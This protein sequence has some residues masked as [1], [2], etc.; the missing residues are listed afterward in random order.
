MQ[1]SIDYEDIPSDRIIGSKY[2]IEINFADKMQAFN[3]TGT[4]LPECA[5]H[6]LMSPAWL[7][8]VIGSNPLRLRVKAGSPHLSPG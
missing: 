1:I 7:S 6:L 8:E 5:A 3:K 4:H 2:K